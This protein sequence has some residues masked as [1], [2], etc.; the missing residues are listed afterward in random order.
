MMIP[1]GRMS[2]PITLALSNRP[3]GGTHNTRA[4]AFLP[5]RLKLM[6]DIRD[7]PRR[8]VAWEN[9]ADCNS[10]SGKACAAAATRSSDARSDPRI[11]NA[12]RGYIFLTK[13]ISCTTA[14][15][16]TAPNGYCS[17]KLVPQSLG[18]QISLF[19][20]TGGI[21]AGK[22]TYTMQSPTTA[23]EIRFYW[24]WYEYETVNIPIIEESK[25]RHR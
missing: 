1:S 8:R 25:G 12:D 2:F 23:K 3:T 20:D 15:G 22:E 13:T 16:G 24:Q 5:Q 6:H 21:P 10:D 17:A 4:D 19:A 7:W 11:R 18:T 14:T 9:R